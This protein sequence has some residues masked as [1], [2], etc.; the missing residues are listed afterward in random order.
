WR[1]LIDDDTTGGALAAALTELG[2]DRP[3]DVAGADYK[4]VPSPYAQDHP[5]AD[6]LRHKMF[7]ARWSEPAP[8]EI[9]GPGFVDH[10][11]DRLDQ[12]GAVHRWLVTNL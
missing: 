5:R 8:P 7:Q 12:C 11:L 1:S 2:R 10:C 3:L 6:L 4:R 9:T